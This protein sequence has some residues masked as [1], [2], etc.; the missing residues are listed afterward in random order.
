MS[1]QFGAYGDAG[2]IDATTLCSHVRYLRGRVLIERDTREI[3]EHM[4]NGIV[5]PDR[6][7]LDEHAERKVTSHR[8]RVMAYGPCARTKSGA[9]VPRGFELFDDVSYVYAAAMQKT[10]TFRDGRRE[11]VIVSQEEVIAVHEQQ[12]AL[13]APDLEEEI[14][15]PACP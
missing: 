7:G 4:V 13:D 11:F 12:F 3:R 10:R 5:R 2:E 14:E 1:G 15:E 8:G 6:T 9:D